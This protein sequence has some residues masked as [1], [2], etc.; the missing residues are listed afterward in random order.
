[1]FIKGRSGRRRGDSRGSLAVTRRRIRLRG[2]RVCLD[3]GGRHG[4]SLEWS[5]RYIY[6]D[7]Q[8]YRVAGMC[9]DSCLS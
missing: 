6:I 3:L 1:M 2:V 8:A 5:C 7:K 4:V 9:G